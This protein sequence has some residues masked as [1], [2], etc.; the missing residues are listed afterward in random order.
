MRTKTAKRET[1]QAA[2]KTTRGQIARLMKMLETELADG[3]MTEDTW[4]VAGSLGY[5][6]EQLAEAVGHLKGV[7]G[8]EIVESLNKK[9]R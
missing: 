6:R 1:P 5:I 4:P 3:E 7:E 8:S 2:C 9:N